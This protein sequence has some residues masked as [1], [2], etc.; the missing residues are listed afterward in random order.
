[1]PK[2]PKKSKK[3]RT[4]QVEPEPEVVEEEIEQIQIEKEPT[5]EPEKPKHKL[6]LPLKYYTKL[7]DLMQ[8]LYPTHVLHPNSTLRLFLYAEYGPLYKHHSYQCLCN[9]CKA[10]C[11]AIRKENDIAKQL[12]YGKILIGTDECPLK[13]DE[14]GN[15]ENKDENKLNWL[16]NKCIH[17]CSTVWN[18]KSGP[19]NL[20]IVS[21]SELTKMEQEI[22]RNDLLSTFVS[23]KEQLYNPLTV[24]EE[25]ELIQ[26]QPYRV[27]HVP[28]L[29]KAEII[30]I[31]SKLP[32]YRLPVD[33]PEE[34]KP[35]IQENAENPDES[36]GDQ[37]ENEN[38]EMPSKPDTKAVNAQKET[39]EDQNKDEENPD[40]PE[41]P[42]EHKQ[43]MVDPETNGIVEEDEGEEVLSFYDI[44]AVVRK[45]R[46][47]RKKDLFRRGVTTQ[48]PR[49]KGPKNRSKGL[50]TNALSYTRYDKQKV[51]EC[52]ESNILSSL[53]HTYTHEIATLQ[54][55]S[56][57][58]VTQNVRL[59]R[60]LKKDAETEWD[61]NCCLRNSNRLIKEKDVL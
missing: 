25:E 18:L 10:K 37:N 51:A 7:D 17:R 54:D 3:K 58:D 57:G 59:L 19:K 4:K 1:M 46:E 20:H 23:K 29:S 14:N 28:Q 5:P 24:K 42:E 32:I 61:S 39:C 53:L 16:C 26:R 15:L 30:K 13:L 33:I 6:P 43:E 60:Y 21:D 12:Y 8:F 22:Q 31:F 56:A 38:A 44:S 2:K 49:K 36:T 40:N 52:E 55:A 27:K 48:D 45:V 34:P 35:E 9:E 47:A 11:K 50:K 41:N